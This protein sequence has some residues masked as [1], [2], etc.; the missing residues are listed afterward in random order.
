M[1][2]YATQIR[3]I[4]VSG[5]DILMADLSYTDVGFIVNFYEMNFGD[6]IY[7]IGDNDN[8]SPLE[9]V[10]SWSNDGDFSGDSRSGDEVVSAIVD[11]LPSTFTANDGFF[12]LVLASSCSF[13][14]FPILIS[15]SFIIRVIF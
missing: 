14:I 11:R 15:N 5:S 12:L 8:S 13:V 4:I 6:S 2:L 1:L 3:D 9:A 10:A 7:D